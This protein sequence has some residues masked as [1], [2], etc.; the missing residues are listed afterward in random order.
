MLQTEKIVKEIDFLFQKLNISTVLD[1]PCGD[2][3]WMKKIDFAGKNLTAEIGM[4]YK[5]IVKNE[6]ENVSSSYIS[7]DNS[8]NLLI[9]RSDSENKFFS[10][11]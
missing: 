1:I 6:F 11:T 4:G 7:G 3:N 5:L 9:N 10:N 8:N 2:F